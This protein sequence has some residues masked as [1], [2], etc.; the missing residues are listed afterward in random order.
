MRLRDSTGRLLTTLGPVLA[1][2]IVFAGFAIAERAMLEPGRRPVFLTADNVRA[3]VVNS[4]SVGICALGMTAIVVAG[5]IDLSVGT[6]LAL[7]A[8]VL[9][10]CLRADWSPSMAVLF[11]LLIGALLGGVNGGLISLLRV[12]AFIVTL[13]TMQIYLG[14]GKLVAESA[15]GAATVRPDINTQVPSWMQELLSTRSQALWPFYKTD[16]L[17]SFPGTPLDSIVDWLRYPSGIWIGLVFAVLLAAVLRY[18]VFGRYVYALGS[19]EATARLCGINV[20]F[21]RIAIYTLGGLFVGL[22]GIYQFSRLSSGNPT[23]GLGLELKVIAAVVIGGGSLS[24]GR[25]SVLGTL[26]GAALMSVIASGCT[27]LGLRNPIQD[28]VLGIII[29]AAVTLDQLRERKLR[30]A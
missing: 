23:S 16:K 15:G 22:A 10:V 12:P 7:C 27:Q 17:H 20:P 18:T 30:A 11:T 3:I 8:T 13:G 29:V 4:G 24:G 19:S 9:A 14:V 25:G 1:V 26:A 5:G 2:L 6:G 21:Y 28:V